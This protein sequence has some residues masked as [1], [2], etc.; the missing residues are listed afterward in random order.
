MEYST[1][2]DI[3]SNVCSWWTPT[4]TNESYYN[5]WIP[6]LNTNEVNFCN[7]YST[8]KTIS[9][10]WLKKSAAKYVPINTVIVAMYWVTAWK[11]AIARIPLT[12][13]QACCNLIIDDKKAYFEYV[14]YFLMQQ[15][16]HL[17]SLANGWAQ[18]NL[19]SNIIKK[20]KIP[21][22]D[23]L[24]QK[25]TANILSCFDKS[26][27]N[28]NKRVKILEEMAE[29]IYK[30]WFVRFRFPW[31]KECEFEDWIPKWWDKVR[32]KYFWFSLDT[33]KR[34]KWWIDDSIEEGI[35][36]LWA[37]SIDSLWVFDYTSVKYISY[38]FY[39]SMKRWHIKDWD[40]LLYKDWAY[41]WKVTKFWNKFPFEKCTVNE[42]VFLV[43]TDEPE[44]QNYLFFT[45][46][47][48]EYFNLMQNLNRNAAQ[49]WLSTKDIEWI[50]LLKPDV[51]VVNEFNKIIDPILNEIFILW[52]NNKKLMVQRDLLLPRL[53]SWKL[54][55]K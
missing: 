52:K 48:K 55:V 51:N 7:I 19:N 3:C 32:M 24:I 33:G 9:E 27:E 41:I 17:N 46:K 26:I 15:S 40:I 8:N 21:L 2:W 23:L 28:N 39:K 29:Q 44:Y 4:S 13:N 54:E 6:W 53:M 50:K 43:R 42:H 18:Q 5:G 45:L 31:Y 25:K 16:E 11:S 49:P 22:P 35:P 20:Y 36:S 34:P 38:E 47:T 30:E 1:I 37:E 12:T 14:Y 10:E